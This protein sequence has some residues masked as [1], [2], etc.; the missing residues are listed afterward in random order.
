MNIRPLIGLLGVLLAAMSADLNEYVSL[1]TLTDVRGALGVSY[2]PGLWIASLYITGVSVGMAFA[3]WN[4]VTFTLRRFTLFAIGL[5]CAATVLI[6]LAQNLQALLALRVIQGL[7]GGLTIPLLM[8]TALR[9]L[10]PQIRIY[11]LAVYALTVTFT[12]NISISLAALWVDVMGDWRFVFL[13]AVP[14]DAIAAVLVWYGLPQDPPR[15]ERLRQFDWRGALL[16]LV[17][18]GS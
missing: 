9:V 1:T 17:G 2:D 4:A 16:I 10:P 3:P 18:C 14:L 6:P 13:Q 5:A 8:T 7:S 15:Y 12:P 11:G